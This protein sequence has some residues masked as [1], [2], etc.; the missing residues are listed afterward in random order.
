MV[1]QP[2]YPEEEF[3]SL[4]LDLAAMNG[5]G[6]PIVYHYG[7]DSPNESKKLLHKLIEHLADTV[8]ARLAEDNEGKCE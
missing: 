8:N 4:G 1:D 6:S 2:I 3:G 7:Y 5:S